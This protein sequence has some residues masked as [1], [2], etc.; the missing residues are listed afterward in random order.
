MST[1]SEYM[2]EALALARL[3]W[4]M[5]NPNPMVG[6]VIVKN[7]EIIGRGFHLKSGEAHAEVNAL[8]DV[9]RHG[10]SAENATLYVTLEPCSSY[11]R[12]PPCTEAIIAAK[13]SKVVIGALDPNPKHAGKAVEILENA[14]I[15]VVCGVENLSCCDLNRHFFR[16]ITS[17]KPYVL[18]KMA[19]T[20][21]GKI[22]TANGE[23]R[24][25]TGVEARRR[26]QQLRRLSDAI[27]IGGNTLR[28]DHPQLTVREPEE[29]GRQPLRIVVS[30]SINEDDLLD[31]FPDG[32]AE[33]VDLPDK[34][35]WENYLISLGERNI[36]M[37]LIE[38]GGALAQA[39]LDAGVVDAVEFHIAPK[40]LGGRESIP[41]LGGKN[42]LSMSEAL[43]L[44]RV[45]VTRYGEDIAVCG[46]LH[47]ES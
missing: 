29:W 10:K 5:T 13:I 28:N 43:N 20:L 42:P 12:T 31:Y 23:S 33:V 9:V 21:D 14:G 22:A 34:E 44:H 27:M 25:V 19:M 7:D 3:G 15:E 24:W 16:W 32:R 38:G 17:K 39:A 36:T 47:Q 1:D 30:S 37:L 4:G 35:A 18:L 11:G 8:S 41:V 6:A 26:V 45:S 2:L 40:L 46:F